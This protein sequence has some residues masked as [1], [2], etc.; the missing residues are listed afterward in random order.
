[1]NWLISAITSLS[2]HVISLWC[3]C[4][5]RLHDCL[6]TGTQSLAVQ[7]IGVYGSTQSAVRTVMLELA[8]PDLGPVWA[9]TLGSGLS[10]QLNSKELRDLATFS[11]FLQSDITFSNMQYISSRRSPNKKADL[12]ISPLL[13]CFSFPFRNDMKQQISK[14]VTRM[15]GVPGKIFL[16]PQISL[17]C[18]SKNLRVTNFNAISRS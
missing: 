9:H 8:K 5:K 11:L 7:Q 3:H 2:V 16:F 14:P 13:V 15:L 17:L 4:A 1:M 18:S 12:V 6:S 10:Q